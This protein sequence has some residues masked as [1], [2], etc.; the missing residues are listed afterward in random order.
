MTTISRDWTGLKPMV[1][2]RS[3]TWLAVVQMPGHLLLLLPGHQQGAEYEVELLGFQ[4]CRR[5][6]YLLH[7]MPALT[8]P[9][10]TTHQTKAHRVNVHILNPVAYFKK[11]Q[12]MHRIIHSERLEKFFLTLTATLIRETRQWPGL[13]HSCHNGTDLEVGSLAIAACSEN[14]QGKQEPRDQL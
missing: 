6:L 3:P 13:S 2:C 9:T 4:C 14:N 5:W 10:L 8:M 7:Q 12:Q 11:K 1:S